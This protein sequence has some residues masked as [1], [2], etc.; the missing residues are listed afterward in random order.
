MQDKKQILLK[1]KNSIR[2]DDPDA[3]F[4]LFGSRARGDSKKTS[5]WDILILINNN[6]KT[7]L[8][9]DKFRSSLYEI[10]LEIGQIISTMVYSKDY[11]AKKL[12]YSPLYKNV[13]KE[14]I[15]L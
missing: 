10:E 9:E 14:G 6:E 4:F 7:Y 5:D 3:E 13:T 2:L 1:I 12:K 8:T 15:R 11:W